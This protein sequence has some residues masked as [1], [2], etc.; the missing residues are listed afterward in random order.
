MLRNQDIICISSIDWDFLWQQHQEIMS[1]YAQNGNNVLFI[2]NTGVRSPRFSDVPRIAHRIKNWKKGLYGFRKEA[3]HLYIYSPLVVPFPYSRSSQWVN[4]RILVSSIR[5]WM[6][7]FNFHDP[8]LWTFLPTRVTLDLAQAIN[9]RLLVYYCTDNFSATSRE[10]RKVAKTEQEVI[11]LSDLVFAMSSNMMSY[12]KRF[13]ADVVYVPMGVSAEIFERVRESPVQRPEDLVDVKPPII[14]YIGG[15]RRS[16][17]KALVKKIAETMR[18]CSLVFVGPIQMDITDLTKHRNIK[19]LG[20][21]D[22]RE[23]PRYIQSFDCCILPYLKDPYTD[24]IS[25]AKLHEYLIMGKPVVSTSLAEVEERFVN[26]EPEG[27]L[28]IA[29]D[30]DEFIGYIGKALT[31][32]GEFSAR[33]IAVA[34]EHSWSEKIEMM[35]FLIEEKLKLKE[36]QV[37]ELWRERFRGL[38]RAYRGIRWKFAGYAMSLL[39]AYLTIFHTPLMWAIGEPLKVVDPPTRAD[40]IVVFAG[41]VGESGQ[42]GQ[43]YE[44]RVVHAVDLY[45]RGYGS[46]LIF[47]SGYMYTIQEPFVMQAL[48][49]SLGV[50]KEATI[51]ET[52]ARNT[53]ENVANVRQILDKNGW[54][55]VLVVSSPYHMRRI[56]MIVKKVDPAREVR[57]TPVIS[58]YFYS[59]PMG[60]GFSLSRRQITVTQLRALL[61]EYAAIAYYWVTGWL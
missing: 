59:R 49:V 38:Y 33:R 58:S 50:P 24:C 37:D 36:R 48:A 44:E 27:V 32:N 61:H 47:S 15:V 28:Y 39:F 42:A 11:R 29:R 17:D 8:I 21:K 13:N 30:H 55:K 20:V 46:H 60:I 5:R 7:S 25:P 43:G 10:A 2:E 52:Q 45:K 6:R 35:S 56:A 4:K 12:C 57:Y 51:L 1:T 41:G 19:F 18:D 26:K 53:Y 3:E 54:N 31:E 22:H 23:I 9:H 14:G 34:K 40:A 16:I